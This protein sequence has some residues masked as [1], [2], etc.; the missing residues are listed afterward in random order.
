MKTKSKHLLARRNEKNEGQTR[1]FNLSHISTNIIVAAVI[2]I[3]FAVVAFMVAR[4]VAN[5]IR[6]LADASGKLAEGNLN[7]KFS[8]VSHVKEITSLVNS[9]HDLQNALVSAV[10]TV[11]VGGS[12]PQSFLLRQPLSPA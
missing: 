2:I 11:K 6:T 5:P 8:A 12:L 9:T 10:G 4:L 1:N 3:L 7:I